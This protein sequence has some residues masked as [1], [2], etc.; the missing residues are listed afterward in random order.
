MGLQ[1]RAFRQIVTNGHQHGKTTEDEE[2]YILNKC[3]YSN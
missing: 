2:V 1:V 3:S